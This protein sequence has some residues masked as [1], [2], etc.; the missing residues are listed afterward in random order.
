MPLVKHVSA[1]AKNVS[2][3]LF[4]YNRENFKF[5]Q[6]QRI[7]REDMHFCDFFVTQKFQL[8]VLV[9]FARC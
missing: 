7:E 4:T 6:D 8:S 9:G 2:E 5:D 3:E 1:V